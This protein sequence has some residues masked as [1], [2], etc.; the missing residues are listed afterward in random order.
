[1]ALVEAS[2]HLPAREVGPWNNEKLHYVARYLD[3]FATGMK[4]KWDDLVY[5]DLLCGPGLC[6]GEDGVEAQG[7]PLL[8]LSHE[9]LTRF[10]FNDADGQAIAALRARIGSD[11]LAEQRP[12]ETTSSDCNQVADVARE[13]LFPRGTRRSVLGLA[14]I[15]NQGFEMS[16]E[17]IEELT[18]GVNLDLLITFMTSFPKRFISRPGFGPDSDFAKFIG[19]DAYQ[20]YVQDRPVI[21]THELLEAYREK[22]G[23]FGY[24]HIDDRIRIENTKGSTIYH[25]VFASRHARGKEFFGRI[26][27]RMSSGQARMPF[28]NP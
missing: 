8:A 4:N 1:M 14:F 2:D 11:T 24:R 3:I 21:Q 12:V 7:S 23:S 13:F 5:A 27:Q 22:L 17:S 28:D 19:V 10:F 26:S 20:K 25:L 9:P 15:D 16:L 6:K 18:R